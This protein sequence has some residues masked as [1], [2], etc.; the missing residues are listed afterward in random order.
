MM[1]LYCRRRCRF[2]RHRNV[3]FYLPPMCVWCVG[4][5]QLE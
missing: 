1:R 2:R 3:T 5:C 4:V